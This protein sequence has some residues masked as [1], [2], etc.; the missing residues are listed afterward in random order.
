MGGVAA[1]A[2]VVICCRVPTRTSGSTFAEW[3]RLGDQSRA[4]ITWVA[5]GADLETVAD[6][7]SRRSGLAG[8]AL[9]LDA[10]LLSSRPPLRSA[11][12]AARDIIGD[13]DSVVV[14]GQPVV[15]H[16]ELLVE[17]GIRTLCVDHFDTVSRSS[18]RPAPSGWPCRSVVWG[19]WEVTSSPQRDAR[20]ISGLLPWM[21]GARAPAGT[22]S[23]I[24]VDGSG[25]E[26][27]R[28]QRSRIEK[29][30][31]WVQ[32]RQQSVGLRTALLSD[33]PELLIA[34]GRRGAG[35]VLKAA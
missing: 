35:S 30:L 3:C 25:G 27:G 4:P 33:L 17:Q 32:R 12:G 5:D 1:P 11:I 26:T 21:F 9:A 10:T 6:V 18:R 14:A 34:A 22:L 29:V 7:L 19:L 24:N 28:T 15:E 23:V 16:R 13:L 2:T 20:G 8:V 31:G